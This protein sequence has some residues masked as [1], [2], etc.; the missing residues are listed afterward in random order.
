MIIDINLQ[1]MNI[2][3]KCITKKIIFLSRQVQQREKTIHPRYKQ[4]KCVDIDFHSSKL[5]VCID[6]LWVGGY[7]MGVFV[8][9][10]DLELIK[11]I[12][13][14]QFKHV[15]GVVKT[16]TGV[17]VCDRNTGVHHLNHQ[18]D[19]TNLIS[20]GKF[21]DISLTT[22]N[23]MYALNYSQGEIHIFVRNQNSWV[24]DTQ[25]KLVQFSHGFIDDKLCT[26]S[27]HVYVTSCKTNCVLV[28]T[29]S[30]EYV[31][32]TGG[33][34]DEAGKFDRAYLSDVDSGGK[35]LV[36]DCVNNR[37]QVFDTQNRVWSELSG[38]EGVKGPVCAGVGDKH[39]W[40]GINDLW[41]LKHLC[42]FEV[43]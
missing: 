32:K 19:Y 35:L 22:D 13:H 9:N 42:K 1:N 37:L 38:L 36:C 24:K 12:E 39:L 34:G 26:T 40:V 20:S 11:H 10:L 5:C 25:F 23:K 15:T 28:Y 4:V 18:G 17:I 33:R 21:S 7:S 43:I 6:E 41:R 8:Y 31:Y 14:P 29:L 16:P 27:T 30:G 2:F 3:Y